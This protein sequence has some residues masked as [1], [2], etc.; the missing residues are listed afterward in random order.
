[1]PLLGYVGGTLGIPGLRLDWSMK[2]KRADLVS[3]TKVLSLGTHKG[4]V[5]GRQRRLDHKGCWGCHIRR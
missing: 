4:K 2:N 5:A 1:M 3:D